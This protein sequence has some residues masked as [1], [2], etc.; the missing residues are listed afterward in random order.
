MAN[1]AN[2]YHHA[3]SFNQTLGAVLGG[4][5]S[6]AVGEF[7]AGFISTFN[8]DS[9]AANLITTNKLEMA[10]NAR[11]DTAQLGVTGVFDVVGAFGLP[12][13]VLGSLAQRAI[14]ALFKGARSK[15]YKKVAKMTRHMTHVEIMTQALALGLVVHYKDELL[16]EDTLPKPGFYGERAAKKLLDT[17]KSESKK[18]LMLAS[19]DN[20]LQHLKAMFE[21]CVKKEYIREES[22]DEQPPMPSFDT[23]DYATLLLFASA[24]L[25][26][27]PR[28]HFVEAQQQKESLATLEKQ[29]LSI[30]E[31]LDKIETKIQTMIAEAI[32]QNSRPEDVYIAMEKG[33]I[34]EGEFSMDIDC[35]IET[36]NS[37]MTADDAKHKNF[38]ALLSQR[39]QENLELMDKAHKFLE[40]R[41]RKVIGLQA[42]ATLGKDGKLELTV[43][44]VKRELNYTDP[45]PTTSTL[46]PKTE[47]GV[48]SQPHATP[49]NGEDA[50]PKPQCQ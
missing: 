43:G 34:L 2:S 26:G 5:T 10:S 12:T 18:S 3:E 27:L 6:E 23:D 7:C 20:L 21:W 16:D 8:N 40:N 19:D 15:R 31:D 35:V 4:D 47:S 49:K 38:M 33:A 48:D 24:E 11:E 32:A 42:G 36:V 1:G 17:L 44:G 39:H 46:P 37:N 25:L 30:E 22:G 13:G 45:T 50:T 9:Y 29:L 28:K 41:D 14:S